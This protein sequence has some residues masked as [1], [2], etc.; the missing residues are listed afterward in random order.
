ML[1]DLKVEIVGEQGLKLHSNEPALGNHCTM[2]F[3][4]AEEMTVGIIVSKHHSLPA[5]CSNLGAA[6]VEHITMAGKER[7]GYVV[8]F[9]HESISH[10]CTVNIKHDVIFL[11]HLVDLGNLR[12][13]V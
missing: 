2:L 13:L 9:R 4:Y 11:A 3:L 10:A 6:N 1:R 5:Q 8:A 12:S 7:Q